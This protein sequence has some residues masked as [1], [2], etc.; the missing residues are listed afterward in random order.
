MTSLSQN[1]QGFFF[2]LT[3]DQVLASVEASGLR[4]TGRCQALSS[5]ENRVYDVELEPEDSK[6]GSLE[7]PRSPASWSLS[8][9]NR[10][11]RVVKFY[12][13]GRWSLEQILQEHEFLLDL[14]AEEI[15]VVAPIAFSDGQTLHRTSEGG[16]YY[17]IFPKIGGR[18]PDELS[19]E[20]LHQVGRLIGRIHQV[21]SKRVASHRVRLDPKSYGLSP[22]KFLIQGQFI[23]LEFEKRYQ[24]AVEQ[25]CSLSQPWFDQV[26]VHRIHGDCHLGNLLCHPNFGR[27]LGGN[28]PGAFFVDF[29][30]LVQGPAVQDLWLLIP[31]RDA[32]A[33]AKREVLL[34]GYEQIRSLDR[35]SLRLIEPL[36]ALR[37][38]HYSAWIARR[39][40][41]PAFP[42]AF[43][44][45]GSHQYWQDEVEDLENQLAIMID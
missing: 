12:R 22:L 3:P 7:L 39:W 25:I 16:I 1:D 24:R 10:F 14:D 41:D 36:R 33:L 26:P 17:A 43:P 42:A 2:A 30:D 29:D 28:D 27:E 34:Q 6:D 32:E 21:G 15:P 11:H 20:Q 19:D 35:K 9:K 40:S 8:A 44:H 13:P 23:P 37:F 5:Y 4:C 38:I 18:A 31:G 45:F